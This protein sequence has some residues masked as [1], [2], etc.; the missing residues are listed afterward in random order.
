[1]IKFAIM[2]VI[3]GLML[4][5]SIWSLRTRAY[6]DRVSFIEAGILKAHGAQ[7][8]PLTDGDQIWGRVQ[9]WLMVGFGSLLLFLGGLLV[10]S[11]LFDTE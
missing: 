9:A 1:M 7:P 3:G 11:N 8:L 4:A 5:L 2:A 6:A 10:A